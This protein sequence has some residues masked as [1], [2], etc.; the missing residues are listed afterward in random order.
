MI[1][2]PQVKVGT[3]LTIG[4]VVAIMND[5]VVLLTGNGQRVPASFEA[6]N[7]TF[8][9]TRVVAANHVKK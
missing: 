5:H 8:D 4:R 9:D 7:R 6:I 2:T 3:E 1:Q